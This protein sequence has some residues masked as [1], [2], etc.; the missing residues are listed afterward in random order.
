VPL[1]ASSPIF[2]FDYKF[3]CEKSKKLAF[4][5]GAAGWFIMA[6]AQPLVAVKYEQILLQGYNLRNVH[7]SP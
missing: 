3:I 5:A 2:F 4:A 7:L 1:L 6:A